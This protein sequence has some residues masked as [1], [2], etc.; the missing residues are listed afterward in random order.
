ME[1]DRFRGALGHDSEAFVHEVDLAT[2][3]RTLR[4]QGALPLTESE[5]DALARSLEDA[6]SDEE[7]LD[8]TLAALRLLVDRLGPPPGG[9]E[10]DPE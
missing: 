10:D 3:A 6:S 9:V 7:C 4:E 1:P 8:N 5:A 2:F